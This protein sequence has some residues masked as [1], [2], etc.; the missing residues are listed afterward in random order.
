MPAQD[1]CT[2]PTDTCCDCNVRRLQA[3]AHRSTDLPVSSGAVQGQV[4]VWVPILVG[5]PGMVGVI[6]GQLVN[7]WHEQRREK[8]RRRREGERSSVAN[9]KK[10]FA[11]NSVSSHRR[12]VDEQACIGTPLAGDQVVADCSAPVQGTA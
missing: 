10:S 7:A 12:R 9:C 3:V 6:S 11:A 2:T 1:A 5:I 8:T 4:S